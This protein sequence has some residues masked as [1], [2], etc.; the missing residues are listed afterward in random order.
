MSTQV[1]RIDNV[2]IYSFGTLDSL[3]QFVS[4]N[5]L[6]GYETTRAEKTGSAATAPAQQQQPPP[7]SSVAQLQSLTPRYNTRRSKM[8]KLPH[9]SESSFSPS[10]SSSS[11]FEDKSI[12]H[13]ILV[14]LCLLFSNRIKQTIRSNET[15]CARVS[16]SLTILSVNDL[17]IMLYL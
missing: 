13:S 10:S 1:F 9:G 11:S 17:L 16:R 3:R 5:K 14:F 2:D 6:P 15:R 8:K 4:K 12:S 7:P